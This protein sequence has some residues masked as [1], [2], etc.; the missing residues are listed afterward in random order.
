MA[1]Q[2]LLLLGTISRQHAT[3]C[4]ILV[5]RTAD[6][7]HVE[8]VNLAHTLV[9]EPLRMS[10]CADTKAGIGKLASYAVPQ[11]D[12]GAAHHA[13]LNEE[14]FCGVELVWPVRQG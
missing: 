5:D 10:A 7:S 6:A 13:L 9:T 8:P 1:A 3:Q 11:C 2:Q 14:P 4:S 12:P